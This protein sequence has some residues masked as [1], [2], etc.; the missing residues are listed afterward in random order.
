MWIH[1]LCRAA[2]GPIHDAS[3]VCLRRNVR[4][5]GGRGRRWDEGGVPQVGRA[6]AAAR[7]GGAEH[8]SVPRVGQGADA[9]RAGRHVRAEGEEGRAGDQTGR[10]WGQFLRYTEV[11]AEKAS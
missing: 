11:G 5:G 6:A 2:G 8:P 3:Q 9:G 10:R 4:P 1:L 7:R